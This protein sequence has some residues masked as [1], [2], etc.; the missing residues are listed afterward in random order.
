MYA[1][2][3]VCV[4]L[5]TCCECACFSA[6]LSMHVYVRVFV[7]ECTC[8]CQESMYAFM[9][10]VMCLLCIFCPYEQYGVHSQLR[11]AVNTR[12]ILSSHLATQLTQHHVNL[13]LED[14][15]A[16]Q[17]RRISKLTEER[18][19]KHVDEAH[20]KAAASA[21]SDFSGASPPVPPGLPPGYKAPSSART[22]ASPDSDAPAQ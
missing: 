16:R 4:S 1:R 3:R 14:Q 6:S 5:C 2:T 13:Q 21:P 19:V 7:C 18:T 17:E 20:A 11:G 9:R 22:A 8:K 12:T 15:L 10:T